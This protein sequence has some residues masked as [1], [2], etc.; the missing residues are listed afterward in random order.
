MPRIQFEALTADAEPELGETG[1][2]FSGKWHAT[3]WPGAS[4]T[5]GGSWVLQIS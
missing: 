5:K 4:A 3:W 1:E 2:A